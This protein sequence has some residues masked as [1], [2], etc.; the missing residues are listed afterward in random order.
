MN[1][2]INLLDQDKQKKVHLTLMIRNLIA[3]QFN[4]LFQKF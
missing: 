1:E 2:W 4:Y 3:F